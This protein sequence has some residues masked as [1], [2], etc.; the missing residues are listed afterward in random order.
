MTTVKD[1]KKKISELKSYRDDLVKLQEY[2][3]GH[4]G[5]AD[6]EEIRDISKFLKDKAKLSMDVRS[7]CSV[8]ARVIDDEI[9][10]IEAIIEKAPV[11]F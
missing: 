7:L 4:L 10:R 8:S 3:L 11:N 5:I 9:S 6:S 1:A 2:F